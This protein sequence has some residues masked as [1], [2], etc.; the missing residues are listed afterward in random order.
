MILI[1]LQ[2]I[3][4]ML[5]II[6]LIVQVVGFPVAIW[7][8]C[9]SKNA[10]TRS[11]DLQVALAL[12]ENFRA[13]WEAEWRDALDTIAKSQACSRS[14]IVPAE[15]ERSLWQMLNWLDWVGVL[16]ETRHLSKFRVLSGSLAPQ[17]IQILSAGRLLIAEDVS[18]QGKGHWQGV[19]II[20]A[21]LKLDILNRNYLREVGRGT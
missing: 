12:S 5:E 8:L 13:K 19:L 20:A 14:Y 1:D 18:N 16:V 17:F 3:K 9:V 21:R 4:P 10:S 11:R 15:F 6:A 2:L 7:A